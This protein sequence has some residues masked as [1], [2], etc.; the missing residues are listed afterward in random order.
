MQP[1]HSANARF[2]WNPPAS[3]VSIREAE[4]EHG[5][6]LPADYVDLL[7]VANGGSTDGN[8]S[9]L[10]VED[11]VQRNLDYEVRE[12]MPGFFMIGDDGAGTAIVIRL[13]DQRIF[14]ADMGVMDPEYA[15]LSADSLAEL[16][17]LGTTLSEREASQ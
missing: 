2:T 7:R 17:E 6:P 15:Q 13:S 8:L 14:E 12:Y 16:L 11:C 1:R 9:I 10:E 3:A 4:D 5:A